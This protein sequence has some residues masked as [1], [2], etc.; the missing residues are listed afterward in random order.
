MIIHNMS[1]IDQ[2]DVDCDVE[3]DGERMHAVL[4][5]TNKGG[6]RG[7]EG[8][9]QY[10]R[11]AEFINQSDQSAA[12]S[13]VFWRVVSGDSLVFPVDLAQLIDEE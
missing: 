11:F 8:I 9:E 6:V 4:T 3:I 13:K 7:C 1:F 12:F 10:K 2:H 5:I